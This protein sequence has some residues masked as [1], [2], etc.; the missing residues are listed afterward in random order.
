MAGKFTD[1]FDSLVKKG[2]KMA[3]KGRDVAGK[4]REKAEK[5]AEV[6]RDKAEKAAAMAREMAGEKGRVGVE[7]LSKLTDRVHR[8]SLVKAAESVLDELRNVVM[9]QTISEIAEVKDANDELRRKLDDMQKIYDK[10]IADLQAELAAK[11][12]QPR[13]ARPA[14]RPARK[15]SATEK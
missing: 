6:A 1:Q 3:E 10:K 15:P 8:E 14:A 9:A 11:P 12:A 7:K 2:S 5:A 13:P 4:A